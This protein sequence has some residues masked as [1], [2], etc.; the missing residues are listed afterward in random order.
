MKRNLYL[1]VVIIWITLYLEIKSQFIIE[2]FVQLILPLKLWI[3]QY[4]SFLFFNE[5]F[6]LLLLYKFLVLILKRKW[7][8][9]ENTKL[10]TLI[11]K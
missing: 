3:F 7:V 9:T 4:C 10:V 6:S 1:E 8:E 5:Y 11:E 2:A